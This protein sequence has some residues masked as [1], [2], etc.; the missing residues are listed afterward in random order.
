MCSWTYS[1]HKGEWKGNILLVYLFVDDLIF[2]G[3]NSIMFD[4]LKEVRV[5]SLGW[6][7]LVSCHSISS[8]TNQKGCF[9]FQ[10]G[11]VKK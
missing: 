1:L 10:K 8:E 5:E 6:L 3:N 2:F 11:Y 7:T 9:I 4:E